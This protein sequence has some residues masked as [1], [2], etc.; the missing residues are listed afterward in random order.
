MAKTEY[1]CEVCGTSFVHEDYGPSECHSCGA[2][3]DW[4]EGICLVSKP[5]CKTCKWWG[6]NRN[7]K[8]IEAVIGAC[9]CPRLM[10]TS[11]Q[12]CDEPMSAGADEGGHILTGQDFGCV[13]WEAK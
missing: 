8:A 13:H 6:P 5:T 2:K 11:M 7:D 1:P 3:Y 10:A 12:V 4:C 9:F